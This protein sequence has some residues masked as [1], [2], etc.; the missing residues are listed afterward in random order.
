MNSERGI[1]PPKLLELVKNTMPFLF[2]EKKPVAPY[3]QIFLSDPPKKFSH[4]EYFSLCLSAHYTTVASFVPT[5]VDNQIRKHLWD[6]KLPVETLR[7]MAELTLRSLGWDFRPVTT[8]YQEAEGKYVSGHQ[9]EWFSVAVGAYAATREALPELAREIRERILAEVKQEAHL[10]ADLKKAKD[11]VGCLRA[12]TLLAHNLGDLDRVIDQ[13]ELPAV[14]PL[15]QAAYKLGHEKHPAFGPLQENLLEA[16]ALNKAFMASE[17]HRHYPLRKVKALRASA[18]YFLPVGPFFFDWGKKIGDSLEDRDVSETAEALLDGFNRL[19]SPKVPLYGYARALGG[20]QK[21]RAGK[22]LSLPSKAAKQLE[23][24]II[25]EIARVEP[26][27]FDGQ[28]A[29]KA[30]QFLKLV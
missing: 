16:G 5:D 15:R 21:S 4:L 13:W 25:P 17:N 14:D 19:S 9:G 7:A 20:I 2:T 18:D 11:G 28:W 30:L 12:C 8:R 10:F 6:Q 26:A 29:K 1:D 3:T 23:K 24:G 22:N 27:A